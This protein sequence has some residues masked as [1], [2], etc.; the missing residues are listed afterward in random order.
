MLRS[1]REAKLAAPATGT[2]QVTSARLRRMLRQERPVP[3]VR[4][5]AEVKAPNRVKAVP[6][7]Q[8]R[9]I[10]TKPRMSGVLKSRGKG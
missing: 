8:E 7:V 6:L 10:V 1:R 9:P 2:T 3:L 5:I 4:G